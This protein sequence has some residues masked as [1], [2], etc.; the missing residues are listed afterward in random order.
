MLHNLTIW[1]GGA[2]RLL[3]TLADQLRRLGYEIDV[4]VLRDDP[5]LCYPELRADLKVIPTS[6]FTATRAFNAIPPL[7][8]FEMA[9]RIDGK[10]DLIHAHNFPSNIAALIGTRLKPS[11]KDVPYVW[12]CNE[13]VRLVYDPSERQRA[14]AA[15]LPPLR[16]VRALLGLTGRD[17]SSRTLDRLASANAYTVTALSRHVAQIIEQTYNVAPVVVNPGVD[18]NLYKTDANMS[19]VRNAYGIGEAPLILTVSRLWPTKNIETSMKAFRIL[20]R[21]VPDAFYMIIGDGPSKD[22]L[23][24][25]SLSLGVENRCIFVCDSDVEDRLAIFYSACD[26]FLFTAIGEPWGLTV[27]EA[28]AAGRPVVASS[29]GGP[30]EFVEHGR[31]GMLVDELNPESCATALVQLLQSRSLANEIGARAAIK[32]SHYSWEKMALAYDKI[33]T[34]ALS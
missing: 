19:A 2:E 28:M 12:Q 23:Q 10:Y 29:H 11:L 13:P 24:R 7:Q 21:Q 14:K 4:Y 8:A 27:L 26:V 34:Q 30:T 17:I 16:R 22:A 31:T 5:T 1:R 25:L 32:A 18:R 6:R 3:F 20:L 33:Y 9:E 15:L